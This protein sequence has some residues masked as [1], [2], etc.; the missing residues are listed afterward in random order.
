MD[1]GRK[2]RD[3]FVRPRAG[4]DDHATGPD[5]AQLRLDARFMAGRR[6][7][8]PATPFDDCCAM[9]LCVA[10]KGGDGCFGVEKSTIDIE[11]LQPILRNVQLRRRARFRKI[12]KWNVP[13]LRGL[14]R[15]REKR[16]SLGTE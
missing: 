1:G 14:H 4:C 13:A 6:N 12:E 8:K 10:Q 15:A 2:N 5:L 7:L 16:V 3:K 9:R 11:Q